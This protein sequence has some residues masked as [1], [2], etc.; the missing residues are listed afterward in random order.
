[1][2]RRLVLTGAN[3]Y[4]GTALCRAALAQG[5]ELA[6][7]GKAPD[8]GGDARLSAYPWRLGEPAPEAALQGASAFIHVAHAWAAD[9]AGPGPDNPNFSGTLQ[10]AAQ[11]RGA[12]IARF[13]FVSTTAAHDGALNTYGKVKL[14][15][16]AE[17]LK[18]EPGLVLIGRLGL[19]YGGKPHGL[20]GLLSK[21]VTV[22]P[23]LPLI[24]GATRL[25]PVHVDETAE[26]LLCI[27]AI[28]RPDRQ[29][30]VLAHPDTVTFTGWLRLLRRVNTGKGLL[31][32]P[33]PLGAALALCDLTRFVPLFPTISRERVYGLVAARPM[34]SADDLQALGLRLREPRQGLLRAPRSGRR[35]LIAESRALLR[36]LGADA[37]RGLRA[38][39]RA[40]ERND[41]GDPLYLS[42]LLLRWPALLRWVDPLPRRPGVPLVRRL[43]IALAFQA[44]AAP[45]PRPGFAA[46]LLQGAWEAAALPARLLCGLLRR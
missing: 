28:A 9:A 39:V 33:I 25:Q 42:G 40:A 20:F 12:G 37:R 34:P 38:L 18:R 13:V 35:R 26:G 15:T 6:I 21:L 11:A 44:V 46:L 2:A 7:L 43:E 30:Y 23:A 8:L 36:Y 10:L 22:F 3:G 31:L 17:L 5:F 1:M 24:G 29:R 45:V 41:G 4:V 19:V 27:A 32:L 16:E 14:A